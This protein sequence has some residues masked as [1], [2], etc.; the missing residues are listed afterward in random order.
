[1][2]LRHGPTEHI[3]HGDFYQYLRG[4]VRYLQR[5]CVYRLQKHCKAIPEPYVWSEFWP[6]RITS[7]FMI[8]CIVELD[9]SH[10]NDMNTTNFT[11]YV[12]KIDYHRYIYNQ[13]I[14][15]YSKSTEWLPIGSHIRDTTSFN[16]T[17]QGWKL[18]N[19]AINIAR[20]NFW[21]LWTPP[22]PNGPHSCFRTT[23]LTQF[24][25]NRRLIAQVLP[26]ILCAV[27]S[28]GYAIVP[29]STPGPEAAGFQVF[30][31]DA[32]R[33]QKDRAAANVTDSRVVDYLKDEIAA[34]VADR[35]LVCCSTK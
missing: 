15:F 20:H 30:H 10:L 18:W 2:F 25:R 24:S 5:A 14:W 19:C 6:N 12:I 4:F 17:M 35:L 22:P 27:P 23:M 34:R 26:R 29:P 9:K 3:P 13:V 1:M 11:Y 31:R 21:C 7:F 8:L 16:V 28:R 33:Q 32:K